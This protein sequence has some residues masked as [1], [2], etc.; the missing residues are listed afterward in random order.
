MS[1][2]NVEKFYE[3]LSNDA[4]LQEKVGK[5]VSSSTVN[6]LIVSLAKESGYDITESD[7]KEYAKN[8][9]EKVDNAFSDWACDCIVAGSGYYKKDYSCF[10]FFGGGGKADPDGFHLFCVMAGSVRKFG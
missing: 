6:N 7:L 8:Q 4:Q 5:L 10:C 3:A 1:K 2:Q 9:S